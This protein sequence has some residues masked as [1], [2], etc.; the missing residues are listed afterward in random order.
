[1]AKAL[2][3]LDGVNSAGVNL[4]TGRALV[5]YDPAV[6]TMGDLT[7]A[8]ARA[9]YQAEEIKEIAGPAENQMGKEEGRKRRFVFLAAA[10][11]SA[12]LLLVMIFDWL[13]LK[14]PHWMLNHYLH[15]A[16]A[17]PVQFW[18]GGPF[19]IGAF[20]A[21]KNR[22]A[23]MDVLV[24]MGTSAAYFYSVAGMAT[25]HEDIYFETSA[26]LITLILLGKMLEARAKGKASEAI[27]KLMGLQAKTARVIRGDREENIPVEEVMPGDLVRVR[28]GEKIPVDGVVE[29]GFSAVDESMITGESMPVDKQKGDFVVGSTINKNGALIFRATKVGQET[30][31]ARIIKLVEEAQGSRAPIQRLADVVAG[32]FV[33]A[34][35]GIALVT[36]LVWYWGLDPGNFARAIK[37]TTAVLVIACPCALGLATP[38][39]IMVG[40]GRGAEKG[41]LIKGGEHLERAH[42]VT[43]VVLDKTG[44]I[45]WGQPEVTDVIPL[46]QSRQEV[47]RLAAA[48]EKNSEHPLGEAVV[49]KADQELGMLSA[50]EDFSAVP[51]RG[52]IA[53]VEGR[54]VLVGSRRMMEESNIDTGEAVAIL[55]RLENEGKT[56]ILVAADRQAAGV[57][58]VADTVKEEARTTVMELQKLGIQVFMI[59]GDNQR[60]AGAVAAQVGIENVLA[61]VLPE[62]KAEEVQKLQ[63]SGHIVAMVGDGI[64]DAPALAASDVGIAIGTGTDVAMEAADI[65]LMRGDLMGIVRAIRLSRATMRIIKQNLFWA[66]F[67]NSLGIPAAAAGFLNPIIAGTAMA[68]SSVSVVSNSLRLKRIK[69]G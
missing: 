37:N 36:F 27:K 15:F 66:L 44:T 35:V 3:S 50:A 11:L 38:T 46:A 1:M 51:G 34:V 31:L 60:T 48:V 43:A 67:Y 2:E 59:T 16:L 54:R 56:A 58:A 53:Q 5:E 45:T 61:E 39:A 21:L 64:N 18:A 63:D 33:P 14:L 12:P 13:G 47:L 41:I 62:R 29:D 28:P 26:V 32:Y 52:V 20:H 10:L 17:T 4:A 9:G 57:I 49:R 8:V 22:S 7:K 30:M 55:E 40:T 42:Q 23:N 24:A 69:V 6:L 19:Y 68:F 25:G 65:T